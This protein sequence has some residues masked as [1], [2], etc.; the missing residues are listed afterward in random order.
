MYEALVPTLC[1][2]LWEPLAA[3]CL[4][5][6]FDVVP[7]LY[8]KQTNVDRFRWGSEQ[9]LWHGV[10]LDGATDLEH[11]WASD[12]PAAL[13]E[14]LECVADVI[15]ICG[16]NCTLELRGMLADCVAALDRSVRDLRR[17]GQIDSHKESREKGAQSIALRAS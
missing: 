11:G 7:M 5:H 13:D 17:D 6:V 3:L 14:R 2:Q 12:L 16:L 9:A 10:S 4:R 15:R 8:K 1:T